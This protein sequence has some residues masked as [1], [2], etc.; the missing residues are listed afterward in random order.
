MPFYSWAFMFVFL[1]TA[2]AGYYL[3]GRSRDSRWPRLWLLAASLVFVAVGGG[4]IDLLLL[5]VSVSLNAVIG[6]RL[7]GHEA[8]PAHTRRM[9][10]WAGIAINLLLLC[11]FKYGAFLTTTL[12]DMVGAALPV[13]AQRFP[14]GMSFYTVSAIM[15][16]VDGYEGFVTRYGWLDHVVFAGMFPYVTMGPIVRWRQI[17]PQLEAPHACRLT[18]AN[19]ACGLYLFSIGLFKKVV[20]ADTF[21][22]WADATFDQAGQ[23]S[24]LGSWLASVAFTLQLYFDFSGYTDMAI[25]VALMFNITLPQNF[26]AALGAS[27]LVDFWRRWHITLTTFIT[28]YLYTPLVRQARRVTLHRALVATFL[29]MTIAG[30]WHG[31]RW[32]FVVFGALHGLGLVIN[33]CWRAWRWSMP[34]LL[35]STLTFAFVVVSL[36]VFRSHDLTQAGQLISSMFGLSG[37]LVSE[38]MWHQIALLGQLG[39]A[40]WMLLAV[41]L[42]VNGQSSLRL[43]QTFRVSW[44]TMLLMVA[45]ATTAGLHLLS[46]PA[47]EFIYRQF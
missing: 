5:I 2:L 34:R 22:R 10:L 4:A 13:P 38:G 8:D 31:A 33:Q 30:L 1:P 16:L 17:L 18:P 7:V 27:S 45:A 21:A 3:T 36:A 25:G 44:A 24:M 14:L 9:W 19:L 28:V 47:R 40:A 42:L 46:W 29:A 35:A 20:L 23:L 15:F 41:A 37:P 26:N 32:T 6:A 43:Q 39:G 11:G 12:N